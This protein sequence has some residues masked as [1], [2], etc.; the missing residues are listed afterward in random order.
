M[1]QKKYNFS[2][3]GKQKIVSKLYKKNFVFKPNAI[4]F[5]FQYSIC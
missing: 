5:F 4:T 1:Q 3:I 2:V